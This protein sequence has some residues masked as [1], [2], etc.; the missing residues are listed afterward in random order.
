M[1]T[2]G[3]QAPFKIPG[4]RIEK[5]TEKKRIRDY[6]I[7]QRRR[8]SHN[9]LHNILSPNLFDEFS[10]TFSLL[11]DIAV[12]ALHP[13]FLVI[14]IITINNQPFVYMLP[15]KVGDSTTARLP[16]IPK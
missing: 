6:C 4:T 9:Q 10:I 2:K 7:F 1:I 8:R 11:L 15:H 14:I 16:Q 13:H 3:I 12:R 5:S